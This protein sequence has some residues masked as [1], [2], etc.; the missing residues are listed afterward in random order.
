M[1]AD[2]LRDILQD[3]SGEGFEGF[4]LQDVD[5]AEDNY[6]YHLLNLYD[7]LEKGSD[8]EVSDIESDTESESDP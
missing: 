2:A 5:K 4:E 1:M 7:T 8:L 6:V 3:D